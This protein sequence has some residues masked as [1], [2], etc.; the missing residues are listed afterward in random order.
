MPV[1][2]EHCSVDSIY[3]VDEINLGSPLDLLSICITCIWT[4]EY[5]YRLV[6]KTHHGSAML[7]KSAF[8]LKYHELTQ[9]KHWFWSSILLHCLDRLCNG[10][11]NIAAQAFAATGLLTER[12]LRG[13]GIEPGH[14]FI[15]LL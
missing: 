14:S 10:F 6:M 9:L 15:Q 5:I 8:V 12:G 1:T 4:V 7:V 3:I 13:L 2:Q 11:L